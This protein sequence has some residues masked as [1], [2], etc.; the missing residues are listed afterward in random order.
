MEMHTK[1]IFLAL[2]LTLN[3]AGPSNAQAAAELASA[4]AGC[5][6]TT[7]HS[8]GAV[9]SLAGMNPALFSKRMQAFKNGDGTIM[10]RIAPA[11]TAKDIDTLAR[12]FAAPKPQA[13]DDP[14]KK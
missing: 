2:L 12:Y 13:A 14:K 5:H 3:F 9:P 7:G 4:C 1:S 8:Q 6:G 11:Y 10:N